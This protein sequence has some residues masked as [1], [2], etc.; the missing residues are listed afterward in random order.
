MGDG[1][2]KICLRNTAETLKGKGHLRHSEE[3]KQTLLKYWDMD[4]IYATQGEKI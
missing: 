2:I 3:D 1:R 4:S